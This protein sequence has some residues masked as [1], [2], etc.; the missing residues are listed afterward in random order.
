MEIVRPIIKWK[1]V[2]SQL[3]VIITF[4]VALSII[5]LRVINLLGVEIQVEKYLAIIR[6][7]MFLPIFGVRAEVFATIVFI[8][9]IVH[10]KRIMIFCVLLYQR[11][12]PEPMRAS[13]LYTP[14]CSEYMILAIK[15]YGCIRG[16]VKGVNRLRRCHTPNGGID[17][18]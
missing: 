13:C 2:G 15:K 14:S 18:P 17:Y 11:F 12:A 7:I 8:S 4:D 3:C 10:L 6:W 1:K 9:M 5:A 16:F